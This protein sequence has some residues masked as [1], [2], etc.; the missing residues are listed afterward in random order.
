MRMTGEASM[1]ADSGKKL[2]F[3]VT[4]VAGGY[5]TECINWIYYIECDIV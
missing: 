2:P 4:F 1:T 3:W 5:H